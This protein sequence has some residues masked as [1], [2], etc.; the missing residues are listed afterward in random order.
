MK[1]VP[2]DPP[3]EPA[4]ERMSHPFGP[5]APH[6][7]PIGTRAGMLAVLRMLVA[8]STP[9]D[10]RLPTGKCFTTRLISVKP[11]FE[12]I[13]FDAASL[14]SLQALDGASTLDATCML[15]AVRITFAAAHV[16]ELPGLRAFRA[17]LPRVMLRLQRRDD[18]RYAVPDGARP[19]CHAR[20]AGRSTASAHTVHDVS[21]GGI[22]LLLPY[23]GTALTAGDTLRASRIEL[24]D[25]GAVISDLE[26]VHV[27]QDGDRGSTLVGCRF[28]GP[29]ALAVP[30]LQRYVAML[31][32]MWQ[33]EPGPGD[34]EASDRRSI[35]RRTKGT[36]SV[37]PVESAGVPDWDQVG[38]GEMAGARQRT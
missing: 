18:V 32:R 25:A 26:V 3:V 7:Q 4:T 30:H 20:L 28:V 11:Q 8:R 17:Q 33:G 10:V 34:A 14:A 35:D 1:H 36:I 16:E 22:G 13:V 9:L 31:E 21:C 24:P 23:P 37:R 15:D 19:V 2:I 5:R 29:P 27:T 38:D 6:A 12:E